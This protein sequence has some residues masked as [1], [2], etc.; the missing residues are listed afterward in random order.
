MIVAIDGPAAS[1]KGTLGKRLAEHYGLRHLDTGLLYRAVAKAVLLHA[2][3][4]FLLVVVPATRHVD[5]DRFPAARLAT[6]D[7]IAAVFRD[8]EY[9][10]VSPFGNLYGLPTYLDEGFTPETWITVEAGSHSDAVRLSA[11]DFARLAGCERGQF[12]R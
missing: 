1:G 12:A 4:G 5:L 3:T 7:E 2:P 10:A 8:C 9:G 11:G 6:E